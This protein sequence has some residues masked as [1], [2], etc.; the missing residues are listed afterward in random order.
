MHIMHIVTSEEMLSKL[1]P[2]GRV[3]S[4]STTADSEILPVTP[5]HRHTE[6]EALQLYDTF[7]GGASAWD[8]RK[9]DGRNACCDVEQGRCRHSLP[10]D[11]PWSGPWT[12]VSRVWRSSREYK[13]GDHPVLEQ[14]DSAEGLVNGDHLQRVLKARNLK[15]D[16][17]LAVADI[18]GDGASFCDSGLVLDL[19]AHEAPSSSMGERHKLNLLMS[20]A[21]VAMGEEHR[22]NLLMSSI[23][24]SCSD[25]Q[26]P[27]DCRNS[28]DRAPTSTLMAQEPWSPG[29]AA[30]RTH[31]RVSRE[32]QMAE[33][34]QPWSLVREGICRKRVRR[35]DP[36]A[37]S[38]GNEDAFQDREEDSVVEIQPK[39]LER[40]CCVQGSWDEDDVDSHQGERRT[41]LVSIVEAPVLDGDLDCEAFELGVTGDAKGSLTIEQSE[42]ATFGDVFEFCELPEPLGPSG[43]AT[44]TELDK[45]TTEQFSRGAQS[46][47]ASGEDCEDSCS[48]DL[49][50]LVEDRINIG[51]EL[52]PLQLGGE[53]VESKPDWEE[54]E[55]EEPLTARGLVCDS[56]DLLYSTSPHGST[57]GP[58]SQW[59]NIDLSDPNFCSESDSV[60]SEKSSADGMEEHKA[61]FQCQGIVSPFIAT[62]LGEGAE[63]EGQDDKFHVVKV[64]KKTLGEGSPGNGTP[65]GASYS[66]NQNSWVQIQRAFVGSDSAKSASKSSS[67]EWTESHGVD[68][69]SS[70]C[71][72]QRAGSSRPN[73]LPP[74]RADSA[75]LNSWE[76]MQETVVVTETMKRVLSSDSD[77]GDGSMWDESVLHLRTLGFEI[78]ARADR[79]PEGSPKLEFLDGRGGHAS[80]HGDALESLLDC[81]TA[82]GHKRLQTVLEESSMH[83]DLL[84][85][86]RLSY[87]YG[88]GS[89]DKGEE[90]WVFDR[91]G[92]TV[93]EIMEDDGWDTPD[94]QV[95]DNPRLFSTEAS[96]SGRV[97]LS[98]GRSA[99]NSGANGSRSA[100]EV[101]R[102][103]PALTLTEIGRP[104]SAPCT[105]T[106]V[107]DGFNGL[108]S[109]VSEIFGRP[110]S[111]G[112]SG[113][114]PGFRTQSR[115]SDPGV[116]RVLS[117]KQQILRWLKGKL[118]L[119]LSPDTSSENSYND[120]GSFWER[121]SSGGR[122][123]SFQSNR[124]SEAISSISLSEMVTAPSPSLVERAHSFDL[125]LNAN[126]Y[127]PIEWGPAG[128][129]Q[130]YAAARPKLEAAGID[131][132]EWDALSN[133][134]VPVIEFFDG[135]VQEAERVGM[136]L[137]RVLEDI[138]GKDSALILGLR[139]ALGMAER[140]QSCA[141]R[142]CSEAGKQ[143]NREYCQWQGDLD[144]EME[145][146]ERV[147]AERARVELNRYSLDVL[148]VLSECGINVMFF[149]RYGLQW[150]NGVPQLV[151]HSARSDWRH[152]TSVVVI[153]DIVL[154][155]STGW[156][157]PGLS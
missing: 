33:A 151:Q 21:S 65:A 120:G 140:P 142:S 84:S 91:A 25:I 153:L 37:S 82:V 72:A 78:P 148:D 39:S 105:F 97:A 99:Y 119:R 94:G 32:S 74:D 30:S 46:E 45:H 132:K 147:S 92:L 61:P 49:G 59:E 58:L 44:L 138:A 80:R 113:A 52:E 41:F 54:G 63:G 16:M 73:D 35:L 38:D 47:P 103:G 123:S 10:A 57:G 70:L 127:E 141:G 93:Q 88:R 157:L 146:L 48:G 115:Q 85:S 126:I 60:E 101:Q 55:E 149:D 8:Q 68:G 26:P 6:S 13:Q 135:L 76:Q 121:H 67:G 156:L 150:R 106:G 51:L 128:P 155:F 79:E 95:E 143:Y 23:G 154:L 29:F 19:D 11:G 118:S 102:G 36:V 24:S 100:M 152:H 139:E 14:E 18:D 62:N 69:G 137:F 111:A 114:E 31:P 71:G 90:P 17:Y 122:L 86:D 136:D 98:E 43:T 56:L 75:D 125:L 117:P 87:L 20:T 83:E 131:I 42:A 109:E 110:V 3:E 124:S 145:S 1:E 134:A 22:I 34:L 12:N 112:G 104:K 64:S 130:L 133:K 9:R 7:F 144:A 40:L 28:F 108:D 27:L 96:R 81:P 129:R 50:I 89:V 116:A 4:V 2:V 107:F 77:Q 5:G 53:I 66:V 15:H